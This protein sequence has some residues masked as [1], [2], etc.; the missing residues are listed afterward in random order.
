MKIYISNLGQ[1]ITDES[2]YA[3]FA[4][5][6][7]VLS[8]I[9]SKDRAKGYKSGVAIVEMPNNMQAATA[10][11]KLNGIIMDGQ[12]IEVFPVENNREMLSQV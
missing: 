8:A 12:I 5:H 11:G 1:K 4:T 6:G 9:I 7:E 3:T 10:I 2:L